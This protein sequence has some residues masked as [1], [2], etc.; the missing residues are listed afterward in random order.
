MKTEE[1]Y[2]FD[3][4]KLVFKSWVIEST[5]EEENYTLTLISPE[6][7]DNGYIFQVFEPIKGRGSEIVLAAHRRLLIE[8]IEFLVK[9]YNKDKERKN[10]TKL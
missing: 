5:I 3:C 2:L 4:L 7:R 9:S 10:T 1:Q 8:G 6:G